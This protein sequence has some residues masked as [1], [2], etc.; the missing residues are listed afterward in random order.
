[1][2]FKPVDITV[3]K[4][5]QQL[6][7][8]IVEIEPN[9][10]LAGGCL[11]DL[12]MNKP[13]KDVDIFI[14]YSA[15]VYVS[16]LKQFQLSHAS[17]YSDPSQEHYFKER[18]VTVKSFAYSGYQI[19]FIFTTFGKNIVNHF[20]FR[21]REFYYDG[22]NV[23]ATNEALEDIA[24]KQFVFGVTDNPLG[25]F[26]RLISFE[27]KYS[28]FT[29]E[30]E[31]FHRLQSFFNQYVCSKERLENILATNDTKTEH[32]LR[33]ILSHKRFIQKFE[34][35]HPRY[36]NFAKY[37]LF[38][39]FTRLQ[40]DQLY[41]KN[42]FFTETITHTFK[43]N[44]FDTQTNNIHQHFKD[45][46]DKNRLR[47]VGVL[48]PPDLKKLKQSLE[49][50]NAADIYYVL[51]KYQFSESLY[52]FVEHY[53]DGFERLNE[54]NTINKTGQ[55]STDFSA[56]ISNDVVLHT[57]MNIDDYIHNRFV[58]CRINSPVGTTSSNLIF[59]H[60]TGELL[61]YRF[62]KP[63]ALMYQQIIQ[64]AYFSEKEDV[65][66]DLFSEFSY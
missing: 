35:R 30:P 47:L 32:A 58:K 63:L 2:Q 53:N 33:S 62:Y 24:N 36:E 40:T 50:L 8:Q 48:S 27:K 23:F 54:L 25:S 9:S 1:M 15:D 45:V 66:N 64:D 10:C 6:V 51:S 56:H 46:F 4:P 34:L 43:E 61:Y 38:H 18:L 26:R 14:H 52:S 20:D 65:F 13:F 57:H 44:F 11:S 42:D 31:S 28:D 29:I 7:Q 37:C 16:I 3:P 59:N 21:F 49:N 17:L 55:F 12:Y 22:T 60:E 19:Q 41:A 5:I 39:N